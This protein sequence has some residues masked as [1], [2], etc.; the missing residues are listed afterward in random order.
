MPSAPR[1]RLRALSRRSRTLLAIGALSLPLA[2]SA[3][4]AAG[5]EPSRDRLDPDVPQSASLLSSADGSSYDQALAMLA[6]TRVRTELMFTAVTAVGV[7][8]PAE[9]R[10]AATAVPSTVYAAYRRAAASLARTDPTCRLPWSLLA[11]IGQVESGQARG[12]QVDAT[13][14]TIAPII[15][16]AL[17]GSPGVARIM[18]SDGGALDGDAVLDRAVG[19]MQFIPGTWRYAGADGN[20]DGRRDPHNVYDASLAAGGYLCSGGRDLRD[21]GQLQAAVLSYNQSLSYAQLVLAYA[22]AF[23]TGK[24]AV[25]PTAVSKVSGAPVP[26][27]TATAT[28]TASAKAPTP[29]PA[30]TPSRTPTPSLRATPSPTSTPVPATTPVPTAPVPTTPAPITPVQ[31]TPVPTT[32]AP[33][34]PVPIIPVPTT[35]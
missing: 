25:L 27:P 22:T 16:P 34:T 7:A 3:A 9:S 14:R 18:D 24:P 5:H 33:I 19:P 13:G 10:V 6:V 4:L 26:T 31:T 11:G 28:A 30:R 20:G 23:G 1:A 21:P 12:G 17:D 29:T 2:A 8:L 32:P 35:P 15:G